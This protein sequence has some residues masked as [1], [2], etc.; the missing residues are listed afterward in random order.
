MPKHRHGLVTLCVL[1]AVVYLVLMATIISAQEDSASLTLTEYE[2]RLAAAHGDLTAGASLTQV[3]QQLADIEEVRLENGNVVTVSPILADVSET[4]VALQ[5]LEIV[6][7]QM[8]QLAQDNS[9]ERLAQLQR[10][11]DRYDLDRPSFWD[12]ILR[13][14]DD[15]FDALFP[16]DVPQGAG[17]VAEIGSRIVVWAI[18]ISGGA[19]LAILLSY[20]LRGLLGGILGERLR[21]R[22]ATDEEMPATAAEARSQAQTLAGTGNY[23]AAVRQLY[24]AALLH[25]D[26]QGLLRFQRDQTNREVLAQTKPGTEVHAHLKP[27]VETFDRVWYGEHEPDRPTFEAYSAEI[28]EIMSQTAEDKRA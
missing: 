6:L 17:A 24:L 11:R 10:V 14:I 3:Q 18:V 12:R 9:S 7:T 5:R 19:L 28:D 20:W 26:E 2:A 1:F 25:L 15:L 13:W 16:D 27:A 8:A 4:D 22:T 21:R 23:R